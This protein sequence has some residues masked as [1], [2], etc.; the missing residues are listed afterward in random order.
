MITPEG[1]ERLVADVESVEL[2]TFVLVPSWGAELA[3][4]CNSVIFGDLRSLGAE[5]SNGVA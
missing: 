3:V 2:I 5:G 4:L 1:L